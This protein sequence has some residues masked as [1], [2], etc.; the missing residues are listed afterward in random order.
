MAGIATVLCHRLDG[1]ERGLLLVQATQGFELAVDHHHAAHLN[2][3]TRG[4]VDSTCETGV[5]S[6]FLLEALSAIC[7]GGHS[8]PDHTL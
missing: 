6:V 1:K 4:E 8:G 5:H 3:E 2:A 7:N